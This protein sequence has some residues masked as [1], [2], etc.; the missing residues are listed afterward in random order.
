MTQERD[1]AWM[2]EAL[3]LAREA[4]TH[5][6]VPVGA[7]VV[8]RDEVIAKS[9]NRTVR[10]QDPTAHAEV[11][12]DPRGIARARQL[13]AGWMLAVRDARAMR[14]VRRRDRARAHGSRGL[15]R[16]G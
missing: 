3:V 6:D 1:V 7:I 11:H 2:K 10:D 9:A 16:V 15:R 14:D 13:A 8:R 4:A 12:R 5:G